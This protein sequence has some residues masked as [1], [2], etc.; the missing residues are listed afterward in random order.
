MQGRE[1]LDGKHLMLFE[2]TIYIAHTG[3]LPD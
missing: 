2:S 3:G 1:Y